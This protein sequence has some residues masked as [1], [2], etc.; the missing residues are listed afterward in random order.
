MNQCCDDDDD[1]EESNTLILFSK[2]QLK[3]Y[4][5]FLMLLCHVSTPLA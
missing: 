2:Q 5:N 1:E 4:Q 3:S